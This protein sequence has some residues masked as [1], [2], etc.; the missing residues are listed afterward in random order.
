MLTI[1]PLIDLVRL[2]ESGYGSKYHTLLIILWLDPEIV[3]LCAFLGSMTRANYEEFHEILKSRG[4]KSIARIR[5]GKLEIK[6]IK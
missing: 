3:F 1:A 2:D 6:E 5:H 4:V